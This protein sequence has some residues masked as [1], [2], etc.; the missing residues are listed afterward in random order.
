MY[1]YSQQAVV[2]E[3]DSELVWYDYEALTKCDPG[4]G[5]WGVVLR[6]TRFRNDS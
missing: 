6:H 2:A 5:T 3:S 4:P 1:S